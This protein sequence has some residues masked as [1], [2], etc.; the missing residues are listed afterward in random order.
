MSEIRFY[1]LERQSLD[2][3]LP[4]LVAKALS[5]G[6]RIV[7]KTSDEKEAERLNGHLWTYDP[8]SFIPHGTKKDGH[9][10]D[11]PVWLTDNNEIPNGADVL[12]LTHNTEHG[13][14]GQFKLICDMFDGRS[15][16]AVQ[17][18]R[19]RWKTYKDAEHDVTYWQQSAQGGWTEKS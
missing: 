8:N 15:D 14:L 10:S 16:E 4:A 6:H 5:K 3:A 11:Q 17:A 13:D 12:I 9:E 2:T 18:A 7:I 1:H 19:G